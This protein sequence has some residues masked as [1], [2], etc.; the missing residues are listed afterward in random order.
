MEVMQAAD[1]LRM[2]P[3]PVPTPHK[4]SLDGSAHHAVSTDHGTYKQN[5]IRDVEKQHRRMGGGGDGGWVG[6]CWLMEWAG[7][8]PIGSAG[9]QRL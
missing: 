5:P 6:R 8:A 9:L 3:Q 4:T 7:Q 2:T 1:K